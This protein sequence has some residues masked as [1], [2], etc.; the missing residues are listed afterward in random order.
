MRS[1]LQQV[2]D[3]PESFTIH[4]DPDGEL[5]GGQTVTYQGPEASLKRATDLGDLIRRFAGELPAEIQ[6][7]FT[8]HD[9]PACLLT[10]EH[11]TKMLDRASEGECQCVPLLLVSMSTLGAEARAVFQTLAFLTWWRSPRT[12]SAIGLRRAHPIRHFAKLS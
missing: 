7:T 6:M 11:K 1:R 4:I 2:Q 5:L 8:K 3:R 9:Q 10:W 12:T